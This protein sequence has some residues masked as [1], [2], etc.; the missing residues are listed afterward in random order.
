[1]KNTSV[2][3]SLTTKKLISPPTWLPASV[4]YETMMG[5]VAY[6]VSSDTSDTDIYGFCMPPQELVF[7]HLGGEI[8][9]F[10][11]QIQ[12]FEQFQIHHILDKSAMGGTGREYD[13]QIFSI[14]KYFQLLMENNPNM[15]DSIF[16]HPTC[17]LHSTQIGDLVREN[18]KIFLHK[19]S[20]HKFKGYAYAQLHKMD[21]K[22]PQEGSKRSELIDKFGFDVKYAYH[23]VRL[24]GEVEQIL[25]EHDI[26]LQRNH[27]QLKAIRRG[28]W[29]VEQIKAFFTEKEKALESVYHSSTLPYKPDEPKIKQLLL[30]CLEIHYGSLDKAVATQSGERDLLRQIKLL[31]E[32]ASV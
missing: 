11:T 13:L 3:Q 27:E 28:E 30:Q 26:D 5:S 23:I 6:G 25:T 29:T 9:G 12:R 2:I 31:C 17:V 22:N 32:K 8:P 4:Q 1:M 18:R 16:T 24:V 10:G 7:P 21:I 19:G 20:W 15:I 14:V